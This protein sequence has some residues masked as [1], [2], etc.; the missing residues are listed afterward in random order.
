MVNLGHGWEYLIG[1]TSKDLILAFEPLEHNA[2]IVVS[3][4][5]YI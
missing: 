2:H 4:K 5:V 1:M 3:L